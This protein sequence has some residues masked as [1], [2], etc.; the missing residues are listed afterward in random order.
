MNRLLIVGAGGHARAVLSV[1]RAMGCW[2]IAGILD[3]VRPLG[4]EQISGV[5]VIGNTSDAAE[6]LAKGVRYAA[7][8]IGDNAERAS[9]QASLVA[10]GFNLPLLR[11]PSSLMEDYATAGDGTVI[12]AGAIVCT[13][14]QLG[15]GVIVNSGAIVD[16]ESKVGDFVHVAPGCRIAGRVKIGSYTMLGIGSC[17]RDKVSI[18][19][20]TVVGAG[21]LVLKDLPANVVAYG[22]PARAAGQAN[23]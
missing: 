22:N 19:A 1:A 3:R 15:R 23:Q 8:A 13:G 7:I 9:L 11:H 21:S 16:H 4:A 18:G 2:E 20:N 17:V 14:V 10:I 5:N 12:C 6:L